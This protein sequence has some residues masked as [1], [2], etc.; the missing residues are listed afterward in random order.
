MPELITTDT[1]MGYLQQA[2]EEKQVIPPSLW[3]EA[4]MKLNVLIGN[5]TD[6]LYELQQQVA[7][8]KVTHITTDE[9][10]NVSKAKV[11][12][13]ASNVYKDMKKQ[14]AKVERIQEFIRLAKIQA[15]LRDS[16]LR[17][18]M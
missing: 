8:L 10:R 6:K 11:F 2:V 12:T 9:K 15:R 7:D 17:N 4:A 3:V 16:E 14:E 13:E 18:Q 1:I 5:E